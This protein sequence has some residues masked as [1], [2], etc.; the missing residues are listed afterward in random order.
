MA[1]AHIHHRNNI[2]QL[3]TSASHSLL[4]S[5]IIELLITYFY[6]AMHDKLSSVK[7]IIINLNH[8]HLGDG[9]YL[10]RLLLQRADT[11]LNWMEEWYI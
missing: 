9:E 11:T 5:C 1:V 2:W 4:Y 7:Y 10:Q 6:Q 3:P 8:V